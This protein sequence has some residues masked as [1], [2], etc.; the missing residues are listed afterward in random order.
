MDEG[1]DQPLSYPEPED[2]VLSF[3]Q[4]EQKKRMLIVLESLEAGHSR[5]SSAAAAGVSPQTVVQWT[6]RGRDQIT[7]V[8]YP[9]FYHHISRAEGTGE[10]KFADIVIREATE[11]HNWRAA[12]FI[13]QK[14][15]KWNGGAEM[16]SETQREQ[17]KAQLKKTQAD[18]KYVEA[19]TKNIEEGSEEGALDR[20]KDLLAEVR[21]ER[22]G[23]VDDADAVN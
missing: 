16:D 20:L 6:R 21:E 4:R 12:M 3:R 1:L 13:L 17:Q 10:Q 7:H 19:R 11:N 23:K 2:I 5:A 22:V 15:Y 18:I 9:W 8:L 14:R